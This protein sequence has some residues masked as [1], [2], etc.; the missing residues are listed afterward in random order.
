MIFLLKNRLFYKILDSIC[1]TQFHYN[2]ISYLA[3]YRSSLV[4]NSS[5]ASIER[6]QNINTYDPFGYFFFTTI[7]PISLTYAGVFFFYQKKHILPFLHDLAVD[8]PEKRLF[9]VG[10]NISAWIMIPTFL[11][12]KTAVSLKHTKTSSKKEDTHVKKNTYFNFLR[13]MMIIFAVLMIISDL[14]FASLTIT[15]S[16]FLHFLTGFLFL[17][18]STFYFIFLNLLFNC[19][20]MNPNPKQDGSAIKIFDWIHT[21]AAVFL[22]FISYL[23]QIKRI[24]LNIEYAKFLQLAAV[25]VHFLNFI[26]LYLRIPKMHIFMAYKSKKMVLEE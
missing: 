18:F 11:M 13:Y 19:V 15:K 12:I 21:F 1:P 2:L 16:T 7:S 10:F 5:M 20:K 17:I 22:I 4:F 9:S 3:I 26:R 8:L 24:P 23:I 14:C 6:P 25:T